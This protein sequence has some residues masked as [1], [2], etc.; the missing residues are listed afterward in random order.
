MKREFAKIASLLMLV[1]FSFPIHSEDQPPQQPVQPGNPFGNI[2]GGAVP[3]GAGGGAA[4][5]EVDEF[6]QSAPNG[7]VPPSNNPPMPPPSND[8]GSP[9][10]G[11][12][13]PEPVPQAPAQRPSLPMNP[14]NR[15]AG[16][17]NSPSNTN[18]PPVAP[19]KTEVANKTPSKPAPN[20]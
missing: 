11:G 2:G 14:G 19:V 12:G 3:N 8:P 9:L 17:G 4:F 20:M 5:P 18:P 1:L 15:R 16:R 13:S 7:F 6:E 10:L